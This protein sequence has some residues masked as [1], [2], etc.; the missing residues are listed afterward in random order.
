MQKRVF[1]FLLA[2]VCMQK[3]EEEEEEE[4]EGEEK[5]IRISAWGIIMLWRKTFDWR[6]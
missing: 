1:L 2:V 3:E 5:K 4:E 6:R